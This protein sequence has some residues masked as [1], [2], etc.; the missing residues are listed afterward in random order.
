MKKNGFTV[1][2]LM[3]SLVI[4][5]IGTLMALQMF[6]SG[7]NLVSCSRI[8]SL[9]QYLAVEKMEEVLYEPAQ[10]AISPS[11]GTFANFPNFNFSIEKT[12]YSVDSNFKQVKVTVTGPQF[13]TLEY[14][15]L[16]RNP[17]DLVG[18]ASN[19]TSTRLFA[20]DKDKKEIFLA[21]NGA[22]TAVYN[23]EFSGE[24]PVEISAIATDTSCTVAWVLDRQA[25]KLWYYNGTNFVNPI[26]LPDGDYTPTSIAVNSSASKILISAK[27]PNKVFYFD[28]SV[29]TSVKIDNQMATINSITT[30]S[31]ASIIWLADTDG[32]KIWYCKDNSPVEFPWSS[33]TLQW[34]SLDVAIN[35]I[36]LH[37]SAIGN[38]LNIL[39]TDNNI[40]YF[41]G[42]L[43]LT[44]PYSYPEGS[45][46]KMG[47]ILSISGDKSSAFPNSLWMND[48]IEK[49]IWYYRDPTWS[50]SILYK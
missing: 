37:S 5:M 33:T 2:E 22:I 13:V 45:S 3:V 18:V 42:V 29:F 19:W 1:I 27:N 11:S 10:S 41:N 26:S 17:S 46:T 40:Y 15:A 12:D 44:G 24:T 43:P 16:M 6:S 32:K 8:A 39:D 14:Y 49:R 34:I 9:A 23:V 36:A 21:I 20:V 31:G 28:G 48:P 47:R 50:S 30:D 25:K 4:F 7:N 35:P 38:K